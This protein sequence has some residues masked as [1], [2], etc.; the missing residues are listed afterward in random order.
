[1]AIVYKCNHCGNVIGELHQQ[2]VDT[3]T[4]G[5]DHLSQEDRRQMIEYQSNGNV[6]IKTICE[7]CQDSL[8]QNPQYHELDFFIQ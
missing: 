4:L 2:V 7:D 8:E 6:Q 1:M 5:L 3:Q